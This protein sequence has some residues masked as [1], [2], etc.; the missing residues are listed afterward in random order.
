MGFSGSAP[1]CHLGFCSSGI[2]SER[3]SPLTKHVSSSSPAPSCCILSSEQLPFPHIYCVCGLTAYP[4]CKLPEGKVTLCYC[5]CIS[6]AQGRCPKVKSIDN[7]IGISFSFCV[8]SEA[9]ILSSWYVWGSRSRL[10]LSIT[11]FIPGMFGSYVI[12]VTLDV[13]FSLPFPSN[14]SPRSVYFLHFTASFTP[15]SVVFFAWNGNRRGVSRRQVPFLPHKKG[16]S[17]IAANT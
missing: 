12:R 3:A 10:L 8:S 7:L 6:R 4:Q 13:S 9:R 14:Q 2:S 16:P 15:L 1:S 5:R 17:C 11:H